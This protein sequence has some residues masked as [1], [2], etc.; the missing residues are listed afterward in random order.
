MKNKK[1]IED[2]SFPSDPRR[3]NSLEVSLAVE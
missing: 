3:E 2:I 1:K